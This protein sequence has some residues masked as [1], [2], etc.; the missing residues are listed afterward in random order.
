[1]T[2]SESCENRYTSASNMDEAK[3]IMVEIL[4]EF[5]R[6]CKKYDLDYWL[7]SGTLLGAYR[8]GGFIPWDDDIDVGMPREDYEKFLKVAGEELDDCYFLQTADTDPGYF[9]KSIPCK[10]RRNGTKY[11]EKLD[12]ENGFPYQ[13]SHC[14]IYIDV[15]PFDRYAVRSASDLFLKKIFSKLYLAYKLSHV[16]SNFPFGLKKII[17]YLVSL[18]PGRFFE[19]ALRALINR[20][21]R[22]PPTRNDV[23]YA[24]GYELPIFGAKMKYEDLYPLKSI[25]FEGKDYLSP[26]NV[27]KY[28]EA[29]YGDSFMTLPPES[30][31]VSH[32]FSIDVNRALD[33]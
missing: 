14:G 2:N 18:L 24:H 9:Y 10:I 12:V 4:D 20:S 1:M 25:V 11:I 21:L 30:E 28:L 15:F 29:H 7:D 19:R 3:K 16:R 8:H 27:K 5:V 6:I 31:R 33:L 26:N 23:Y 22:L 32:A 17:L 13:L